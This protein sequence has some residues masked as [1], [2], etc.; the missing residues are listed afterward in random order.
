MTIVEFLTARYDEIEGTAET[1]PSDPCGALI[2]E[3]KAAGLTAD[4][5]ESR[6]ALLWAAQMMTD[7]LK[8]MIVLH[9]PAYVLADI[10]AGAPHWNAWHPEGMAYLKILAEPFSEHPDYDPAWV[11]VIP[12]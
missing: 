7:R 8:R 1:A 10:A 11:P 5:K 9:D 12:V 3:V 2:A 6:E 4:A